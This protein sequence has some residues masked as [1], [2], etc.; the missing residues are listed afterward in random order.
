MTLQV[1]ATYENGVL[2]LDR[3]LPFAEHERVQVTIQGRTSWVQ[4]TAG[5]IPCADASLIE[6]VA[7]DPD[8]EYEQRDSP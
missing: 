5:I 2:R 4:A 8:L 3:P 6:R 7:L 1:E